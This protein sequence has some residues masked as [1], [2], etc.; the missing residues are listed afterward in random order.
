[1][2]LLLY[3]YHYM[4][5]QYLFFSKEEALPLSIEMHVYYKNVEFHSRLLKGR[6]KICSESIVF[7]ARN[8]SIPV[9]KVMILA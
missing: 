5:E 4:F 3:Y 1:M 8:F 9:V 7:D 2:T 6:L